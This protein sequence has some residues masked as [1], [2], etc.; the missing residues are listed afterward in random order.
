MVRDETIMKVSGYFNSGSDAELLNE[1]CDVARNTFN[2][3]AVEALVGALSSVVTTKQLEALLTKWKELEL[4][5]QKEAYWWV[6][7]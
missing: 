2:D 4:T 1:L 5:V 7:I 6:D 3:N